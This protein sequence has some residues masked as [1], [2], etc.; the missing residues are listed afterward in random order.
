MQSLADELTAKLDKSGKPIEERQ[1][2]AFNW[3]N[4]VWKSD[5]Y[6]RAHIQVLDVRES[7]KMWI[8]HITIFPKTD[9]ASPIYGFDLMAGANKIT[10]IFHDFSITGDKDH[11]M[12][13]WF[14]ETVKPLT[15]KKDRE[16]PDWG[17][18]IFSPFMIAAG[19]VSSD[20][21]LNKIIDVACK[22]MD[23]Y[24]ANVG[25]TVVNSSFIPEHNYYCKNQKENVYTK[26]FLMGCG[27]PEDMVNIYINR[28][29]FPELSQ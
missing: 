9:D 7:K 15:W 24:L 19:N 1:L 17:K 13:K 20:D 3:F 6:R 21:E 10:G 2:E 5:T 18:R 23:Y 4:K 16:L 28:Y 25:K 8:M 27:Y 26:R 12:M 29:L 22:S 11:F 14:E